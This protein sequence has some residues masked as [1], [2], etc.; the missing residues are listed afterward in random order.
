[1]EVTGNYTIKVP[2]SSD[3]NEFATMVLKPLDDRMLYIMVSK[4][5]TSQDELTAVEILLNGLWVSGDPV[6]KITSSL[7]ALR[8]ASMTLLP[9]LSVEAGEL[10]KN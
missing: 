5:M 3:K 1:M 9:I 7:Y 8:S 6:S 4:A 2:I 10:K